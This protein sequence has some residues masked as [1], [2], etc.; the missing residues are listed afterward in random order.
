MPRDA[1]HCG[2]RGEHCD[3][4][5]EQTS[6][7]LIT[8]LISVVTIV[9]VTVIIVSIIIVRRYKFESALKAVIAL[10]VKQ[11][12][13]SMVSASCVSVGNTAGVDK[14]GSNVYL[15]ENQMHPKK[16]VV[17]LKGEKVMMER[18]SSHPIDLKDRKVL[19]ELKTMRELADENVCQFM[20]ICVESP[21]MCIL[22]AYAER[23]SLKKII[24][25]R[26]TYFTWDFK[27]SVITDVAFGMWYLHQSGVGPHGRL[28]SSKCVVDSRWTCKVT[29]HGLRMVR[30]QGG[31]CEPTEL[32]WHSPELLNQTTKSMPNITKEGNVF[33]FA[34]ITQEV[35]LQDVPYA[36]NVPTLS[37]EETIMKVKECATPPYR[38]HVPDVSD[39]WINLLEQCWDSAPNN[40]PNF[41][42]IIKILQGINKG[43][44]I[45][46]VVDRMIRLLELHTNQLEEKVIQRTQGIEEEKKKMERLLNELLPPSVVVQLTLGG[47]VQPE[48]FDNAS[49]LFSDIVGFTALSTDATP[50]EVVVLLNTM[51]TLF[52]DAAHLYDVYKVATIGDAYMAASGV[53]IRNGDKHAS[54]ICRL[55]IA[56]LHSVATNMSSG[57]HIQLRIGVHSGPCVGG[58]CGVKMPR[59]LLFGDTVEVAT[60]MESSGQAM[61][62]HISETTYNV[63]Q[64]SG[65]LVGF[66][67]EARVDRVELKGKNIDNTY[68]LSE[69]AHK[70]HPS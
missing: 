36:L 30:S 15:E 24:Q 54:E 32:L 65:D 4:D 34:I 8:V 39:G 59:Y 10:C 13:I 19:I 11:S 35:L 53:P 7:I 62:V 44:R 50:M 60:K 52:D 51:Y 67:V 58:V 21:T 2:W 70:Q 63:L 17:F 33:S 1:P 12:D 37:A 25:E 31:T 68:W 56:L 38:P 9:L 16:E 3:N 61:K 27:I 22:M 26:D 66:D 18:L 69:I 42:K 48:A 43:K 29:G 55:A 64:Q 57:H 14:V 6:D 40:R 23:G 28:T 49:I 45:R 46:N 41:E 5:G 20:G 47:T